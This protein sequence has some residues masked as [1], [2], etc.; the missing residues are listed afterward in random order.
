[1][2]LTSRVTTW[3]QNSPCWQSAFVEAFRIKI[4]YMDKEETTQIKF[5]GK[6]YIAWSWAEKG[7]FGHLEATVPVPTDD[8]E[9]QEWHQNNSNVN[10]MGFELY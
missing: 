6:N 8:K 1:M 5:N 10:H 2:S 3:G 4:N 9:Q 7:L